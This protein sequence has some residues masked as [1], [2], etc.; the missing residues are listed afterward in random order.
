MVS[1]PEKGKACHE[2]I[3]V[4]T[5]PFIQIELTLQADKDQTKQIIE[6]VNTYPLKDAVIKIIYHVPSGIK[7]TVNLNEVQ[8]ACATAWY[9]VGIIPIRKPNVRERRMVMHVDMDFD[10]IIR[11]YF[12]SKPELISR[13]EILIEKILT[14]SQE[15]QEHNES[16][17]S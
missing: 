11:S 8:R 15:A 6:E 4:P 3:Q 1:I 10:T 7:D 14:L 16:D 12:E 13:K 17:A 5:R 2:F 9:I